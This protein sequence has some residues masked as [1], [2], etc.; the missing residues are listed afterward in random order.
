MIKRADGT[1]NWVI[2]DSQRVDTTAERLYAN[3]AYAGDAN[4]GET[5]SATG[6]SPRTSSTTDT[7]INGGEYIYLAIK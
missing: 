4:Q 2:I 1:G 5:F 6:F 3:E 7:N